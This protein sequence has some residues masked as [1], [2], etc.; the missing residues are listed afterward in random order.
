MIVR[1]DDLSV[2][3]FQRGAGEHHRFVGTAE[4]A[5]VTGA[6]AL[7][8]FVA[9]GVGE[10]A[11]AE[12]NVAAMA[13]IIEQSH[14][15]GMPILVETEAWGETVT[16]PKHADVLV[17]GCRLAAELGADVVNP[18][19]PASVDDNAAPRR[20]VPGPR[21]GARRSKVDAGHLSKQTEDVLSAKV[22]GC[23]YGRNVWQDDAP[24]SLG[25]ELAG[26]VHGRAG[27]AE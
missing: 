11:S 16:D 7:M 18:R 15:V 17:E 20:G 4:R 26:R 23:V 12:D 21:D 13:H 1:A 8:L 2:G 27:A 14:A 25:R 22:A 3:A 10:G 5:A 9:R 24:A 6:D 19:Y